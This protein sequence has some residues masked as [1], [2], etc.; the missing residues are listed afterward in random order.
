MNF[1]TK[2]LDHIGYKLHHRTEKSAN[3][4]DSI[5]TDPF[6]DFAIYEGEPLPFHIAFQAEN[7]EA[8]DLFNKASTSLG[9]KGYGQPGYHKHFHEK[10]YAA[11][12]YDPDGYAI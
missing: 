10:Y 2:F 7:N 3:F 5:S 12:V 6:G 8:V 1:I 9:A 4:T 11:F